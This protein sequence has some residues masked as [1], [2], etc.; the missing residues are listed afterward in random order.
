MKRK[1]FLNPVLFAIMILSFSTAGILAGCSNSNL[2]QT[3]KQTNE[4]ESLTESTR[5]YVMK[6]DKDAVMIPNIQLNEKDKTFI[7]EY[8]LFSSVLISGIYEIKDGIL[9]AK[10]DNGNNYLFEVVDEDTLKFIQ[11]GS[12]EIK[13]IDDKSGIPVSDGAEFEFKK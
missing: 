3:E 7:L 13:L 11:D 8:D 10:S 9:S 2:I 5:I 6:T 12:A 4:V 1:I